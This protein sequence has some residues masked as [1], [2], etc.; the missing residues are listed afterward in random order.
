MPEVLQVFIVAVYV[1]VCDVAGGL[2]LVL[3][4]IEGMQASE[5]MVPVLVWHLHGKSCV[6]MCIFVCCDTVLASRC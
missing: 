2:C 6:Y 4:F 5:V 3:W 1:D